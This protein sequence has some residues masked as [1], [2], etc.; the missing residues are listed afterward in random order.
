MNYNI[1][2]LKKYADFIYDNF[3]R[4]IN[5]N[6]N[7]TTFIE[8]IKRSIVDL[9]FENNGLIYVKKSNI[10]AEKQKEE[11]DADNY[12]IINCKYVSI[13][14]KVVDEEVKNYFNRNDSEETRF[15]KNKN[16]NFRE[17]KTVLNNQEKRTG[18]FAIVQITRDVI[19]D[20]SR[21]YIAAECKKRTRRIKGKVKQAM[22]FFLEG[23]TKT[24]TMNRT[25]T[26]TRTKTRKYYRT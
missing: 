16:K 17:I 5:L 11:A 3:K 21:L 22:N 2:D 8:K 20:T 18:C 26:R 10:I 15:L 25:K 19:G 1:P 12:K 6:L 23:G 24:K 13:R 14:N 9:V 7:D 4:N